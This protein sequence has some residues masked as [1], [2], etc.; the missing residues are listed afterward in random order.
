VEFDDDRF[1]YDLEVL[2]EC[3]ALLLSDSTAKARMALILLDSLIDALL[4]RRLKLA[5]I[6]S[7]ANWFMGIPRFPKSVRT[8]ARKNFEERLRIA[9]RPLLGDVQSSSEPW[10]EDVEADVILIGHSYRN[11]AYHRDTH[12]PAVIR[13][14]AKLLFRAVAHA[15]ARGHDELFNFYPS[16]EWRELLAPFGL[17]AEELGIGTRRQVATAVA[18]KLSEGLDEPLD[19]L[20]GRFADDLE[21]RA[22]H[23]D[24]LTDELPLTALGID[25]MLADQEFW[26][27]HGMDDELVRLQELVDP[28]R[29]AMALKIEPGSGMFNEIVDEAKRLEPT[30][31]SRLKE[32]RLAAGAPTVSL[33][34][35]AHARRTAK[36]IRQSRD[37][38]RVLS[39][40]QGVDRDLG[41]LERYLDEAVSDYDEWQQRQRDIERGK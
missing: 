4:Y 11:A 21:A 37:L 19:E 7:E 23:I 15:F 35:L 25:A 1:F 36:T 26:D 13:P 31:T 38:S 29:R 24:D 34:V 39:D 41:V 14:L 22:A 6:V 28:V 40:Y 17:S 18:T 8:S 3:R 10:V 32:L 33:A 2:Y 20:A 5:Y 12:N 30:Y 16:R 27:K 9:R